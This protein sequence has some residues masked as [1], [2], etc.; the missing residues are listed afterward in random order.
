MHPTVFVLLGNV[1]LVMLLV[2]LL[3]RV[4]PHWTR[5]RLI[6]I[7]GLSGP[8]AIVVAS[9]ISL[10]ILATGVPHTA[11][12]DVN[13]TYHAMGAYL[14]FI[15]VFAPVGALVGVISAWLATR[16]MRTRPVA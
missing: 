6:M 9:A 16:L 7:G 12:A 4:R 15:I 5:A 1:A 2:A 10:L 3:H 13:G 14:F 8:M 11:A